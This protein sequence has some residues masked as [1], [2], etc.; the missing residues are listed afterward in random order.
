MLNLIFGITQYHITSKSRLLFIEEIF[1]RHWSNENCKINSNSWISGTASYSN[2]TVFTSAVIFYLFNW[3]FSIYRMSKWIN[4][5]NKSSRIYRISL[6]CSQIILYL[7]LLWAV[8]TSWFF[9]KS[10]SHSVLYFGYAVSA[11]LLIIA[12]S[13]SIVGYYYYK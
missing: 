2:F 1:L 11:I 8:I 13:F 7:L 10:F 3:L 9:D 12:F 5:E 4:Y 6:I